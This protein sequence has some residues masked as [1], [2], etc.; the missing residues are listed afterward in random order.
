MD[1]LRDLRDGAD[2]LNE[3]NGDVTTVRFEQ[4]IS[5]AHFLCLLSNEVDAKPTADLSILVVA[6]GLVVVAG[7]VY[8]GHDNAY[9]VQRADSLVR[10]LRQLTIGRS[11]Y[12][13]A[14]AIATKFGNAPP[15]YWTNAYPKENCA[16]NDH[17]ESCA[18]IIAMNDS[19]IESLWLNI[20]LY[21]ILE[22]GAG[23]EA[24]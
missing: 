18:F 16:A 22:F 8:A 2:A 15:P 17:F 4:L 14:E 6:I 5:V 10:N 7:A 20:P 23:G 9:R 11:D 13:V 12:K 24:Q 19:P 3:C 1:R 21:P